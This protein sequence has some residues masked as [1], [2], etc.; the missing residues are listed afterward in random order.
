MRIENECAK[1]AW[2]MV[3]DILKALERIEREDAR[4]ADAAEVSK[5]F[6]ETPR[7]EP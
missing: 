3:A 7:Q 6:K 2:A 5:R 4:R 1:S